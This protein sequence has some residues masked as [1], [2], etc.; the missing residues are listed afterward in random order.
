MAGLPVILDL[1]IMDEAEAIG[2]EIDSFALE[3][4]L[5]LPVVSTVSTTKEGL[6]IL[7]M[8]IMETCK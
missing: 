4:E 2:I 5:G 3:K 6:D 1:N 7:K 8:K